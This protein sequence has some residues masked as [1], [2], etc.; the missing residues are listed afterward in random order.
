MHSKVIIFK[1]ILLVEIGFADPKWTRS[2][3]HFLTS[4][5]II[6]RDGAILRQLDNRFHI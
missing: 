5:L 2:P 4:R 3:F 1:Y 6:S